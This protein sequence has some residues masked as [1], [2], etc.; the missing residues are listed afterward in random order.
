MKIIWYAIRT[1]RGCLYPV[2]E[3][4]EDRAWWV[5]S[6][7][8]GIKHDELSAWIAARKADG[9]RCHPVGEAVP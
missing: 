4:T 3:T 2:M 6:C 1:A 9:W 8:H 5:A 7:S